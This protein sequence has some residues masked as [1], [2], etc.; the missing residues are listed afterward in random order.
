MNLHAESGNY[1]IFDSP[2]SNI[3]SIDYLTV[4]NTCSMAQLAKQI[5]GTTRRKYCVLITMSMP[6]LRHSTHQI[7]SNSPFW[8]PP[9]CAP[10][11]RGSWR[12]SPRWGWARTWKPRPPLRRPAAPR[13]PPVSK[14]PEGQHGWSGVGRVRR[15]RRGSTGEAL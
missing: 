4:E 6:K 15:R 13:R 9:A 3:Q 10:S 2:Q 1:L 5:I 12:P 7:F 14:E 11:P 8:S